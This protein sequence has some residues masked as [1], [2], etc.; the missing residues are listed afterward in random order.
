MPMPPDEEQPWAPG[1]SRL[2][3]LDA[4][5]RKIGSRLLVQKGPS[6]TA[7]RRCVRHRGDADLL[8]PAL[9]TGGIETRCR[10]ATAPTMT[11]C[12][13][14][15]ATRHRVR[16]GH[17]LERDSSCRYRVFTY[18]AGR[19]RPDRNDTSRVSP[20]LHFG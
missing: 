12:Q 5:L 2:L 3:A 10:G 6:S 11:A 8:E 19:D 13:S 20:H 15:R 7:L 1:P 16:A 14:S 18:P 17:D 9:R 4:G